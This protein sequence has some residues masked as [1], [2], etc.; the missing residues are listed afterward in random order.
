MVSTS[1]ELSE[2]M[3]EQFIESIW[4][5]IKSE[6]DFYLKVMKKTD[7]KTIV[8]AEVESFIKSNNNE[9]LETIG[10]NMV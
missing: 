7:C 1:F 3:D 6:V 5:I 2:E 4:S 9:H 8:D 10:R